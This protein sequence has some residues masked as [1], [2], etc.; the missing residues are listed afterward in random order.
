[1]APGVESIEEPADISVTHVRGS[2]QRLD[3]LLRVKISEPR[4]PVK[5]VRLDELTQ[6]KLS[7]SEKMALDQLKRDLLFIVPQTNPVLRPISR[8]YQEIVALLARGKRRGITET[9]GA[10]GADSTTARRANGRYR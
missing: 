10:S 5:L 2:E 3:E 4:N 9:S 1:M 6:H 7:A 8:E